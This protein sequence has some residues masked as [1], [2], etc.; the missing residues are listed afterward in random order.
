MYSLFL[1]ISIIYWVCVHYIRDLWLN[2]GGYLGGE[3]RGKTEPSLGN[4]QWIQQT[5]GTLC[6]CIKCRERGVSSLVSLAS[7]SRLSPL[8]SS[9][10]R[11]Q[12]S[13][14]LSLVIFHVCRFSAVLFSAAVKPPS[15]GLMK[16]SETL[17]DERSGDRLIFCI[18]CSLVRTC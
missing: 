10:R 5:L 9:A 4:T 11:H 12:C 14:H 3:K 17:P 16:K 15:L 18:S 1:C 6:V 8:M 2:L 13:P 7:F